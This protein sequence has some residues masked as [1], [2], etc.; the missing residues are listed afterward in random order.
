MLVATCSVVY[1]GR[2]RALL[3]E[4][5]RLIMVKE[6]G[7]VSIHAGNGGYKPLNW[8][9]TPTTPPP[10]RLEEGMQW[11]VENTKGERLTIDLGEIFSDVDVPLGVEPGLQK[12]GVETE[13]QALL[14]ETPTHLG[15]N[16]VLVNREHPTSIGPVDLL[17]RDDLG[18]VVVEVK[19]VAGLDAVQQL[20]RYCEYLDR[21]PSLTPVRPVLAAQLIKPQART[22]AE[23]RG[24][25]CVVLDYDL[26]RGL[27]Q[28]PDNTLF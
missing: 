8:M 22:F 23:D 3:P 11:I 18:H 21:D 27:P 7:S 13:I 16:M 6:D 20:L 25:T 28:E 4:A 2:L 19:R 1:E 14:A 5:R 9:L 15:E 24:V 12:E 17:C 26:L 10:T